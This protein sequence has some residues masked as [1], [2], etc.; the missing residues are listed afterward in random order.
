M[1]PSSYTSQYARLHNPGLDEHLRILDRHLVPEFI[2]HTREFLDG[3]HAAGVEEA[4]SSKPRRVDEVDGVDDERIPFPVA[5]TL[6]I[7]RGQARHP[8]VPLAAIR[9]DVAEFLVSAAV[10]GIRVVEEDDVF[11]LLDDPPWRVVARN[12]DRLARHDGI[13]LVRPL[14]EFLNLVPE[15]GLVFG[16]TPHPEPRGREPLVVHP[17]VVHRLLAA[18]FGVDALAFHLRWGT[19]ASAA[20]GDWIRSAAPDSRQVRMPVNPPQPVAAGC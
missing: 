20:T 9:R 2:A 3:M 6:P 4:A 14:I 1:L 10:I 11:I 18:D 8:R 13:F 15:L 12:S 7:V 17:E 19:T 5:D 16:K